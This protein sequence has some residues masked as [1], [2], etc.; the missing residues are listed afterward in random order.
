M[1]FPWIFEGT[2]PTGTITDGGWDSLIDT[3]SQGQIAHYSELAQLPYPTAC[4]FDSSAYALKIVLAGGTADVYAVEGDINMADDATN[5]FRFPVWFSP[6]FD[7]TADDT[8]V[9]F[10]IQ[11]V[12]N[13]V[14][15]SM[16]AR[17]VAA[18]DVI[19]FG[20]G[21]ANTGAVPDNFASWGAKRGVWYT[22][23]IKYLLDDAGAGTIDLFITP[24]GST[25]Q[26]TADVALTSIDAI[27]ATHG[28]MGVQDHLATTLGTIL[29]GSL[30]QDDAQ[31]Y[32]QRDRHPD[33]VLLTKTGQVFVGPGKIEQYTLLPGAA[34]DGVMTIYD[35]DNGLTQAAD[36]IVAEIK[37]VT[38][39]EPVTRDRELIVT[40]GAYVTLA[41]TTP[42]A[43]V[44]IR[45]SAHRTPGSIRVLGLGR[46]L[47]TP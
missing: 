28:H 22:V 47:A 5:Y 17:Y 11:G 13:A 25:Q 23:E 18:T 40:R 41:G 42:R 27:A 43:T 24:E 21:G 29:Y 32:A 8:F 31:I 37:N 3:G 45:Q 14:V 33:T 6:D 26:A 20:I 19:N 44:S 35:T 16:G 1:A 30:I 34:T 15:L 38:N 39:S 10:E 2:F 9:L 7:A 36:S 46:N 12:G 4:P